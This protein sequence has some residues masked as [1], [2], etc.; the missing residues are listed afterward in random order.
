L[1][2]DVHASISTEAKGSSILTSP[3]LPPPGKLFKI[4]VQHYQQRPALLVTS[5][6]F[7]AQLVN[8]MVV[9]TTLL[10]FQ[11]MLNYISDP[12]FQ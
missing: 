5:N 4:V 2:I 12:N 10:L 11:Y 8:M 6:D 9:G 7:V 1:Q 3:R